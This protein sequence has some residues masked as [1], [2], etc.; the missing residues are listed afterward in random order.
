MIAQD[1]VYATT[2]DDTI[3]GN[4]IHAIDRRGNIIRRSSEISGY[5]IAVD[6]N[7]NTLWVVGEDIK[8]CNLDLQ[9]VQQI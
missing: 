8:K 1:I 6:P 9:V 5:D 3:Y 2:S 7:G 4:G